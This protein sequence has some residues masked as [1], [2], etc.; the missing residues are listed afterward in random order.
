MLCKLVKIISRVQ[1]KSAIHFGKNTN[2]V[3][4]VYK[5]APESRYQATNSDLLLASSWVLHI[6]SIL[7]PDAILAINQKFIYLTNNQSV[8]IIKQKNHYQLCNSKSNMKLQTVSILFTHRVSGHFVQ[9]PFH[10]KTIS[11]KNIGV[12]SYKDFVYEVVPEFSHTHAKKTILMG[13]LCM[14]I[15]VYFYKEIRAMSMFTF[16]DHTIY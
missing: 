9:R 15:F 10:T 5:S 8:I 11:Y 16:V 13:I 1:K 3:N 2:T 14:R 6:S 7:F 12:T 4:T